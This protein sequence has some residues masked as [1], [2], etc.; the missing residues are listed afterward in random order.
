MRTPIGRR[1]TVL[2]ASMRFGQ[3]ASAWLYWPFC[4]ALGAAALVLAAL[5]VGQ[6]GT[7]AALRVTAR[8]SFLVFWLAYSGRAM[9]TL[10]G[11]AFLPV[12]QRAREFGL[13]FASAHLVHLALVGWLC[14]IGKAPEVGTFIFFGSAAL[15]TYLLAACSIDRVREALG[16]VCWWVLRVIGINFI[17][18]AFAR[19]FMRHRPEANVTYIIGYLPFDILVIAGPL[20]RLTALAP[21]VIQWR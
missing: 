8:L 7:A 10:F 4:A 6:S 17:L 19:D 1:R 12:R 5:G 20:L 15:C 9:A 2:E 11:P 16:G 3:T 18:Y 14:W 13:A 21:N